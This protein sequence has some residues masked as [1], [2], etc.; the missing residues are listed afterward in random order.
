[1]RRDEVFRQ[2]KKEV[3]KKGRR[4][5]RGYPRDPKVLLLM[6][7]YCGVECCILREELKVRK[8]LGEGGVRGRG[9]K[10]KRSRAGAAVGR[11]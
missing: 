3:K 6:C 9:N 7:V 11:H 1:M 10:E 8:M 5:S 2:K 4:G